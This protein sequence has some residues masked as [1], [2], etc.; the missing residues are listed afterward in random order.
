MSKKAITIIIIILIV[1]VG[2][3]YFLLNNKPA[4]TPEPNNN[5]QNETS[6]GTNS[7]NQQPNTNNPKY[8]IQGMQIEILK[9]GS[10]AEAKNGDS[11]TVNYTGTLDNGTVFDSSLKPGRQPLEFTLGEGRGIKG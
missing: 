5:Q 4:E 11:V 9:Q 6:S 3:L 1:V 2:V 7:G 8:N 10:G